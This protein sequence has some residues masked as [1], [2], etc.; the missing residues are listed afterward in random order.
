LAA[1]R[2]ASYFVDLDQINK[3]NVADLGVAWFYPARRQASIRLSST[4]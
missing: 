3:S 1:R 2:S 4:M